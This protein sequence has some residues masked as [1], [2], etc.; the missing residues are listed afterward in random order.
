MQLRS[1]V[2]EISKSYYIQ[3]F[4][5]LQI[6]NYII[7]IIKTQFFIDMLDSDSM[8]SCMHKQ[9]IRTNYSARESMCHLASPFAVSKIVIKPGVQLY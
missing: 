4:Y 6:H 9:I 3:L 8:T 1:M 2:S 7:A 5:K